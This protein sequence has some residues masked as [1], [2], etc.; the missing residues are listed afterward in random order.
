MIRL[1]EITTAPEC[2]ETELLSNIPEEIV[3][4]SEMQHTE[5]LFINGLIRKLRPKR[6][7]EIGVAMGTGSV[8]ILNAIAD[9]REARLISVDV[10]KQLWNDSSCA[11]GFAVSKMY[12]EGNDQW[13]LFSGVDFSMIAKSLGDEPFDFCIIDTCHVHPAESLNFITAL[14]FLSENAVVVFHD[15]SLFTHNVYKL[16]NFPHVPFATKLCFDTITG[17]KLK[18]V[19]A[20]YIKKCCGFSNIGAVQISADTKKYIGNVFDMFYFPWGTYFGTI[21]DFIKPMAELI[22]KY[23][24][25]EHFD[26]FCN[27]VL[28]NST[29]L[30]RGFYGSTEVTE[31][32]LD[33][34]APIIFY[35]GGKNCSKLLDNLRKRNLKMP[36]AIWDKNAKP[37]TQIDGIPVVKPDFA[38][39]SDTYSDTH[40]VI[41]I[42][43]ED[44]IA[45]VKEEF[46][47]FDPYAHIHMKDPLLL[48][49]LRSELQEYRKI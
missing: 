26:I 3:K 6:I 1:S 33:T 20:D 39:L 24:S 30:R 43:N 9:N 16:S 37:G 35:G 45:Q 34:D 25:P 4:W 5:R 10:S 38:E 42:G 36:V 15:L 8:V 49:M 7:L 11:T 14:P 28:V 27:A 31:K 19:A 41:T 17:E 2:F 44:I 22:K 12:P 21:S 13:T 18:P 23:Y 47:S 48:E 40:F 29:H 32:I 46:L